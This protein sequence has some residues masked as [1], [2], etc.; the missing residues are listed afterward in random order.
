LIKSTGQ[1]ATAGAEL[2]AAATATVM[3]ATKF[4]MIRVDFLA[5]GSDR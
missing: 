5:A 3:T 1:A 4:A 2:A